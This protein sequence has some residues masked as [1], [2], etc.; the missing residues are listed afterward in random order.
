VTL[1]AA[2]LVG[3]GFPLEPALLPHST[4]ALAVVGSEEG[5]VVAEA[6]KVLDRA[7]VD[8]NFNGVD[9]RAVSCIHSHTFLG[10]MLWIQSLVH[11]RV[12]GETMEGA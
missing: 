6:W 12:R 2:L 3:M 5:R 4:E 8:S 9:W 1:G 10:M 11:F 7:F